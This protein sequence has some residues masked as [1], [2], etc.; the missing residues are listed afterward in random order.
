MRKI[1]LLTLLSGFCS[2]TTF[3]TDEAEAAAIK[4]KEI[5]HDRSVIYSRSSLHGSLPGFPEFLPEEQI[6]MQNSMKK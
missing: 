1:L 6:L 2:F 3:A 4:R 5:T